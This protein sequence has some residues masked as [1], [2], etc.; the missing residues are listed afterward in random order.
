MVVIGVYD[1]GVVNNPRRK[2]VDV[3]AAGR[4]QEVAR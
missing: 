2:C 3:G 1:N 4:D